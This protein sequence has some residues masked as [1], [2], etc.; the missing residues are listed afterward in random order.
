[1]MFPLNHGVMAAAAPRGLTFVYSNN[2]STDPGLEGGGYYCTTIQWIES[3]SYIEMIWNREMVVAGQTTRN[4]MFPEPLQTGT[5]RLVLNGSQGI[6]NVD[7][8]GFSNA[9]IRVSDGDVFAGIGYT[10]DRENDPETDPS[11]YTGAYRAYFFDGVTQFSTGWVRSEGQVA[12][13][14]E[15]F[16][17][18]STN[19]GVFVMNGSERGRVSLS[20]SWNRLW[21][22]IEFPSP[23]GTS[24]NE[25]CLNTPVY[26]YLDELEFHGA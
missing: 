17:D 9:A 7:D 25:G 18:P 21:D 23:G 8:F 5:P 20:G 4:F 12:H 19:E 16:I 6:T 22:R 3:S 10:N 13:S 11:G 14:L 1:M 2:F 24:S 15:C 26:F